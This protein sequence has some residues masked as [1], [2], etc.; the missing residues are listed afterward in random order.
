MSMSQI[1]VANAPISYGAFELTVG[2][3]PDVPDAETLLDQVAQ[4][5]Y[6]GIDLGPVGY[7]GDAQTLADRL[8]SRGLGL[9][10]GYIEMPYSDHAALDAMMPELDL[11]LDAFDLVPDSSPKPLPTLADAGTEVRRQHP[12]RAATDRSFGLDDAAWERFGQGLTRA[13]EH[14]RERGYEPT[15]HPETGTFVE[16]EWEVDRA[17]E[18]TD[19]GLCLDTG[20]L[21]VGGGDAQRV[22]AN[23]GDRI[24]HVHLKDIRLEVLRGIIDDGAPADAI[25][26]RRAFC[27]LGEGDLAVDDVLNAL[28]ETGYSGWLVVEQDL[29]PEPTD[30]PGEVVGNQV[31]N[32]RFLKGRGM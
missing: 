3:N 5:G 16:A 10:G 12:G 8:G 32:R 19:I 20:H 11:L 14:C 4:A 18:L 28:R 2:I 29:M 26:R 21:L 9:A 22:I 23:W 25:W 30:A 7:L 13:V 17:L 1:V 6:A 24:N 31:A 15:L 27:T